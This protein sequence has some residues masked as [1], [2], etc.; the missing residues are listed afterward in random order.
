[1]SSALLSA[2]TY[3]SQPWL[4]PLVGR[5]CR[6][7]FRCRASESSPSHHHS[8]K[9]LHHCGGTFGSRRC[10]ALN[11]TP[12][13]HR[14]VLPIPIPA[15]LLVIVLLLPLLF[16]KVPIPLPMQPLLVVVFIV[17]GLRAVGDVNVAQVWTGLER[18]GVLHVAGLGVYES[19]GE[20][21][22]SVDVEPPVPRHHKHALRPVGL[23]MGGI[24]Q[25]V[26]ASANDQMDNAP[27]IAPQALLVVEGAGAQ[28][29]VHVPVDGDVHVVL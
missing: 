21:V 18:E 25:L 8:G 1:M 17:V 16:A 11:L 19:K 10:G 3:C 29:A 14:A 22:G 5:Q 4:A 7:L 23:V 6:S 9:K 2:E 13:L 12:R 24:A 20:A 27:N 26:A 28:V 15:I